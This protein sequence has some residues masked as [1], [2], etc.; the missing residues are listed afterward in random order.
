MSFEAPP[1]KSNSRLALERMESRFTSGDAIPEAVHVGFD[2]VVRSPS[3]SRIPSSTNPSS[4]TQLVE[5][6]AVGTPARDADQSAPSPSDDSSSARGTKRSRSSTRFTDEETA[7]LQEGVSIHGSGR[8]AFEKVLKWGGTS[9][10][11]RSAKSL[12]QKWKDFS[13]QTEVDRTIDFDEPSSSVQQKTGS[14][15]KKQ[16]NPTK[17]SYASS[18]PGGST[19]TTTAATTISMAPPIGNSRVGYEPQANG[20]RQGIT[21]AHGVYLQSENDRL[22]AENASLIESARS[23]SSLVLSHVR[24]EIEAS[25]HRRKRE[26]ADDC[27]AL[28]DFGPPMSQTGRLRFN[29]G[30]LYTE[31]ME[32]EKSVESRCEELTVRL[33]DYKKKHVWGKTTLHVDHNSRVEYYKTEIDKMRAEKAR[34]ETEMYE[35]SV[36]IKLHRGALKTRDAEKKSSFAPLMTLGPVLS[37]GVAKRF[38][39][40]TL[41][42]IGGMSEVWRAYD[43]ESHSEVVLKTHRFD[44]ISNATHQAKYSQYANRE[45]AILKKLKHRNIVGYVAG[46]PLDETDVNSNDFV[47]VLEYCDGVDLREHLV[48]RGGHMDEKEART[49]LLQ[50]LSGM[51]YYDEMRVI[52][53]DLKPANLMI[54]SKGVVKITDFGM[55]K[56]ATE[57]GSYE[58]TQLGAGTPKFLAP[59]AY[60]SGRISGKVDVWAL[61][62][63]FYW[64]L[65]GSGP[66]VI[67]NGGQPN[68]DANAMRFATSPELR[69]LRSGVFRFPEDPTP[70]EPG[71][72]AAKISEKAKDFIRT[73]LRWSVHERPSIAEICDH[74][75]VSDRKNW[76]K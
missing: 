56:D 37:G 46:F 67:P 50:V 45:S 52:H 18:L 21:A 54:D 6:V 20:V 48:R 62:V 51:R 24:A 22:R 16:R 13:K 8:G 4:K 53:H 49:A 42:G 26:L 71:K 75:Y 44:H 59:E 58:N 31:L 70:S 38:I 41:V 30:R 2:H 1:P 23:A 11:G 3:P 28:G 33:N 27:I 15:R 35:L 47:S 14:G 5:R 39:L 60:E 43:A 36:R 69:D 63:T 29:F 9:F 17:S 10:E 73:C 61:G 76:M 7:K 55:A 74:P 68:A 40:R 65:Y 32:R 64:L 72:K 25:N 19:A 57:D 34:V 66:Y 12:R